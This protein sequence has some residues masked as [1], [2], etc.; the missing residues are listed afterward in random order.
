MND[1][2]QTDGAVQAD[3]GSLRRVRTLS[4]LLDDAIRVPGTDVRIGLDPIIGIVPGVGDALTTALS[5]YVV[6]EAIKAGVPKTL[7]AKMLA[8]IAV[9]A[10]V[11]TIPF[12][13]PVVDAFWKANEWNVSLLTEYLESE[14]AV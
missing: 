12:V 3:S 10:L 4:H 14:S 2:L 13:G 6:L 8:L 1:G 5:L 9:D 7:L 11:G